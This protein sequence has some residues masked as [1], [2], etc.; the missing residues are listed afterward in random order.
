MINKQII[1]KPNIWLCYVKAGSEL[2]TVSWPNFRTS[3]WECSQSHVRFLEYV[4]R[5]GEDS[6]PKQ[7]P[8]TGCC[9]HTVHIV[10]AISSISHAEPLSLFVCYHCYS[11]V[12]ANQYFAC[13]PQWEKLRCKVSSFSTSQRYP[14]NSAADDWFRN[15]WNH[16]RGR[17][18]V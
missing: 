10:L 3:T 9:Q 14:H 8:W 6:D 1:Y 13:R 16:R 17:G 5:I 4:I 11:I 12:P 7:N 15:S 18:R 2:P